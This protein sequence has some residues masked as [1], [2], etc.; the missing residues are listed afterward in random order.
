MLHEVFGPLL[1]NMWQLENGSGQPKP[2]NHAFLCVIATN[3]PF[4]TIANA[5]VAANLLCQ[6]DLLIAEIYESMVFCR[7]W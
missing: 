3:L 2:D 5:F 4:V 1:Q 7:I 6:Q